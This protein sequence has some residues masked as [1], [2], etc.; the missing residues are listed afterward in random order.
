MSV[1]WYTNINIHSKFVTRENL[2]RSIVLSKNESLI[3]SLSP[4]AS[5]DLSKLKHKTIIG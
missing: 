4:T 1:K 2:G 3:S 5:L